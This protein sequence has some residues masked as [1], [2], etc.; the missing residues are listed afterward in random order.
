MQKP[1]IENPEFHEWNSR[2]ESRMGTSP[3]ILAN[4]EK[5]VAIFLDN[6][7]LVLSTAGGIE[8]ATKLVAAIDAGKEVN[9]K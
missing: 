6:F 7:R 2:M 5:G 1:F 8:L 3:A 4:G 9:Q